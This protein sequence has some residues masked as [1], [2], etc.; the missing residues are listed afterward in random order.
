MECAVSSP[1]SRVIVAT[2]ISQAMENMVNNMGNII[3]RHS[4]VLRWWSFL[5]LPGYSSG[6][7]GPGY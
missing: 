2:G 4:T 5:H 1:L 7:L 3:D 6:L